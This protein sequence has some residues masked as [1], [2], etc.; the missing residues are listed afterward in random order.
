[1]LEQDN[2]SRAEMVRSP[3]ASLPPSNATL[4][5]DDADPVER[6]LRPYAELVELPVPEAMRALVETW[7]SE[8]QQLLREP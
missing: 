4:P 1:M 8:V 7:D 5:G 2:L 3:M 6:L